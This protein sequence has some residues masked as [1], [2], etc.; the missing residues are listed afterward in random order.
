LNLPWR[1]V[2]NFQGFGRIEESGAFRMANVNPERYALSLRNLPPNF[3]VKSARSGQTD[4]LTDGID[5]TVGG[6]ARLDIVLSS[7][8]ASV[9]GAVKDDED[10]AIEDATVV[11][12]PQEPARQKQPIFYASAKPDRFGAFRLS[13]L[14]P[15][16]YRLYAFARADGEPWANA[17]FLVPLEGLAK[18]VTLA[19]GES[20]LA[21]VRVIPAE[22]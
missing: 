3:Y 11:A 21:D 17:A 20:Q 19:E 10:H 1:N 9:F 2:G 6:G 18:T 7:S 15:G 16:K 4:A 13:G 22:R 12:V 5:V 14:A 8:G